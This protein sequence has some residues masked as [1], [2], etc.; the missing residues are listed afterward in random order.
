MTIMRLNR[1]WLLGL[2]FF[3]ALSGSIHGEPTAEELL[4][5]GDVRIDG[6]LSLEFE[7][8]SIDYGSNQSLAFHLV[9]RLV[10][11]SRRRTR[12]E[13]YVPELTTFLV[14][15][16]RNI[17][18]WKRLG[19][20]EYVFACT[21]PQNGRAIAVGPGLW[22]AR[23]NDNELT[24]REATGWQWDYVDGLLV[25]ASGPSL[26]RF[27]V[28]TQGGLVTELESSR[29]GA[30]LNVL[31]AR[32]D[33]QGRV[34]SLAFGQRKHR[35][36]YDL[37]GT[38]ASRWTRD[39]NGTLLRIDFEY[40]DGLLTRIKQAGKADRTYAWM[41]VPRALRS[42]RQW[43]YPVRVAQEEGERFGYSRDTAGYA[44]ERTDIAGRPIGRIVFNPRR[45]TITVSDSTGDIT[46]AW[47]ET[48]PKRPTY[49]QVIR[50]V[51]DAGGD[52]R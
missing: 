10:V 25:S 9:H 1:F 26:L 16:G 4:R 45:G 3:V 13:F 44:L 12:S 36:H 52:S 33:K 41:E 43:T 31:S 32:Y 50:L 51:K 6:S 27:K 23:R 28:K 18:K 29:L 24:I 39:E 11:D 40:V 48:N 20:S 37:G 49:G 7:L 30:A 42:D 19:G 2:A 15:F 21:L 8:G 34:V 35:F 38:G 5:I 47:I 14:P 46:H 17:L 22:L